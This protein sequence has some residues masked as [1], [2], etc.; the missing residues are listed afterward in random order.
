MILF[1]DHKQLPPVMD[2]PLC[3]VDADLGD[4]ARTRSN[5]EKRLV[6]N[7]GA[8]AYNRMTSFFVLD[9]PVRQAS[10]P[11]LDALTHLR[12]GEYDAADLQFW[13]G[14]QVGFLPDDEQCA[15]SV[16]DDGVLFAP[17]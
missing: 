16:A 2:E 13:S 11:L 10:G 7:L 4:R 14:R 15:F 5:P 1:G 9:Q 8:L 6:K 17:S 3:Q 12:N